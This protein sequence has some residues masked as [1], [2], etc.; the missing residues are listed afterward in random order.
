MLSLSSPKFISLDCG[1]E[2]V[3]CLPGDPEALVIRMPN[4]WEVKEVCDVY[5][6]TRALAELAGHLLRLSRASRSPKDGLCYRHACCDIS[7]AWEKIGRGVHV[8]SGVSANGGTLVLVLA[9]SD[10]DSYIVEVNCG[11]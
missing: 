4:I 11:V 8:L 3:E 6:G 1:G 7:D 2:H 5:K 9:P 10:I